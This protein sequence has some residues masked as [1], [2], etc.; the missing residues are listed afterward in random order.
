MSDEEKTGKIKYIFYGV[1]SGDGTLFDFSHCE[2]DRIW[3]KTIGQLND[4]YNDSNH[5]EL[6]ECRNAYVP[7]REPKT[8]D[9]LDNLHKFSDY[10]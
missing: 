3:R 10:Q 7:P 5:W 8:L 9:L 4:K 6:D 2:T 1:E